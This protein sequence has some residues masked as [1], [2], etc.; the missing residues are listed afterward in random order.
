[1][2]GLTCAVAALPHICANDVPPECL[3]DGNRQ[4]FF[5]THPPPAFTIALI[6][7]LL[8]LITML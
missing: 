3:G 1:M 5:S 7:L 8:L 2:T 6:G 4:L